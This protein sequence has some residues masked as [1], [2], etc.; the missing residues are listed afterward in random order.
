LKRQITIQED[1]FV[2]GYKI[3]P[4]LLGLY[5]AVLESSSQ[6]D[7]VHGTLLLGVKTEEMAILDLFED[8]YERLQVIVYS[9]HGID[10]QPAVAYVWN[11][12]EELV[13]KS[14]AWNFEDDYLGQEDRR[15]KFIDSAA[16]FRDVALTR[17]SKST[18]GE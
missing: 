18:E 15:L 2:T 13:D 11:Q 8:E 3:H 6:D 5:P 9:A 17:L 16:I 10:P 7:I 4:V 12:S 14:R 1:V